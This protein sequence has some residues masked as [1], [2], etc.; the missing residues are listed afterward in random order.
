MTAG[1]WIAELAVD[2]VD[3]GGDRD[4]G[5]IAIGEPVAEDEGS[6]ACT[7]EV[8]PLFGPR[9][10]FGVDALQALL[11]GIRFVGFELHAFRAR[12]GRVVCPAT[13]TDPEFDVSLDAY[14]GPLLRASDE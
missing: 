8:G 2:F 4:H 9:P 7:C 13:A 6:W 14:F 5:R 3:P 10:L 11:L 1:R 12:G